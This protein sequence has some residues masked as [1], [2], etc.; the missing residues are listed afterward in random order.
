M[1]A[2]IP[3]PIRAGELFD[4]IEV[5]STAARRSAASPVA[6]EPPAAASGAVTLPQP[7]LVDWPGALRAVRGNS[8]LLRIVVETALE[9]I[10]RLMTAIRRAVQERDG[11]SLRLSAHTLKGSIRYFGA[12]RVFQTAFQLEQMGRDGNLQ[13]AEAVLATLEQEV[14]QIVPVLTEFVASASAS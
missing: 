12:E 3:K 10:P 1:D 13:G 5:L 4:A 11:Q 9:E 8:S 2:Y 6:A 7:G 14:R